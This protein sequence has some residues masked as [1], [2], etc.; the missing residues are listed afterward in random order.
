MTDTKVHN[1][2]VEIHKLVNS[3]VVHDA[4]W[5]DGNQINDGD[6]DSDDSSY[7]LPNFIDNDEDSEDDSYMPKS[8]RM[9]ELPKIEQLC[10]LIRRRATYQEIEKY[11]EENQCS[12]YINHCF[13]KWTPL[14]YLSLIHI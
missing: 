3:P 2:A 5:H 11:F 1:A 8:T 7:S 9:D 10:K 13:K 12:D 6:D 14:L 4:A